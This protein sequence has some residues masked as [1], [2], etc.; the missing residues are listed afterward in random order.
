MVHCCTGGCTSREAYRLVGAHPCS[1]QCTAAR[2]PRRRR[3]FNAVHEYL[4]TRGIAIFDFFNY[5][6]STGYGKT[7]ARLNDRR[8][9]EHELDDLR[10]AVAWLGM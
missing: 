6:G 4:L 9:R 3:A 1:C 5:R 7:F 2:R 10:D 8:L